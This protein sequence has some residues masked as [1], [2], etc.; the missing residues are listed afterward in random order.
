MTDWPFVTFALVSVL[1][2]MCAVLMWVMMPVYANTS[3][4]VPES[5]YGWIPT[6]NALM[7]VFLQVGVTQITKR[8]P[9]LLMAALGALFYGLGAGS[10][11]LSQGFGGFWLSMVVM[12]IG[13]LAIVPTSSTYVANL[14]PADMR[15]RYMGI[16]GLTWGAASGL[17]PIVGGLLHDNFGPRATWYGGLATGLLCTLLFVILARLAP[18]RGVTATNKKEFAT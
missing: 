15:G 11:A 10:V 9:P 1:V 7:V 13:E 8:H 18:A 12:T 4:G 16:F 3:F 17:S 2:Q 14:A 5:Q 6:T